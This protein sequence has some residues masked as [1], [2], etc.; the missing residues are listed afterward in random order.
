MKVGLGMRTLYTIIDASRGENGEE[1]FTV[2][3][4]LA[5]F[6]AVMFLTD[7]IFKIIACFKS[8]KKEGYSILIWS[9]AIAVISNTFYVL[10]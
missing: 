6:T 8:S 2:A 5:F 4:V 7:A 3:N 9:M 1:L 10:S